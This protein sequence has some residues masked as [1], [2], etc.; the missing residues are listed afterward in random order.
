M[1]DYSQLYN[2]FLGIFNYENLLANIYSKPSLSKA[3]QYEGYLINLSDYNILKT[4]IGY[5]NLLK[6]KNNKQK[7]FKDDFPNLVKKYKLTK[8]D[9]I[10]IEQKNV[11]SAEEILKLIKEGNKYKIIDKNL[12][13]IIRAKNKNKNPK[14]FNYDYEINS[15]NLKFYGLSFSH[16]NNIIDEFSYYIGN[17]NKKIINLAKSIIEYYY[18]EEQFISNENDNSNQKNKI[19]PK[20]R[21]MSIDRFKYRN[22]NY[23]DQFN[24]NL[25]NNYVGLLINQKWIK[26]WKKYTN[27]NEIKKYL[28]HNNEQCEEIAEKI[29]YYQKNNNEI[30]ELDQIEIIYFESKDEYDNYMRQNNLAIINNKFYNCFAQGMNNYINVSKIKYS[31]ENNITTIYFDDMQMDFISTKNILLG[32]LISNLIILK[33]IKEFQEGLN[34]NKLNSKFDEI[35][36]VEK[37]WIQELKNKYLYNN[38]STE[39]KK[40]NFPS[41]NILDQVSREYLSKVKEIEIKNEFNINS[42]E[43]LKIINKEINN[44]QMKYITEF[45]IINIKTYSFLKILYKDFSLY[46][47]EGEYY[48]S[49]NSLYSNIIICFKDSYKNYYYQIGK[50]DKN[51]IYNANYVLNFNYNIDSKNL[52]KNVL[53]FKD[54]EKEFFNRI[55][56]NENNNNEFLINYN[57]L[58]HFYKLNYNDDFDCLQNLFLSI[59]KFDEEFKNK[60]MNKGKIYSY[61]NCY[62]TCKKFLNEFKKIFLY[63]DYK[64]NSKQNFDNIFSDKKNYEKLFDYENYLILETYSTIKNKQLLYP[65][66]FDIINEDIFNNLNTFAKFLNNEISEFMIIQT[67]LIINE[68][69]IIIKLSPLNILVIKIE[70]NNEYIPEIIFD[71][72]KCDIKDGYF[73]ILSKNN[74]NDVINDKIISFIYNEKNEIIGNKYLVNNIINKNINNNNINEDIIKSYLKIILEFY[75]INEN[76]SN[77]KSRL[78]SLRPTINKEELYIVNKKWVDEFRYIFC[79][80]EILDTLNKNRFLISNNDIIN[81]IYNKMNNES[82]KYLNNLNENIIFTKFNN[83]NLYKLSDK[84]HIINENN[85]LLFFDTCGFI[86]EQLINLIKI[87][88]QI[89]KANCIFGDDKI[90]LRIESM[91]YIVILKNNLFYT[92]YIINLNNNE[93]LIKIEN[94]IKIKGFDYINKLFPRKF[95]K[96]N[97]N[98]IVLINEVNN[99]NNILYDDSNLKNMDER[100]KVLLILCIYQLKFNFKKNDFKYNNYLYLI[101]S[102]FLTELNHDNLFSILINIIEKN[103]ELLSDIKSNEIKEK[104]ILYKLCKYINKEMI[105]DFENGIKNINIPSLEQYFYSRKINLILSD[106]KNINVYNNFIIVD[107]NIIALFK[108]IF[109]F[110][111]INLNIINIFHTYSDNKNF[112]LLNDENRVLLGNI[113][114]NGNYFKLEYIFD[115]FKEILIIPELTKLINNYYEYFKNNLN[116]SEIY[117]NDYIS[118]IFLFNKKDIIGYCYKYNNNIIM[119]NYSKYTLNNNLSNIIQKY[120]YDSIL[121]NILIKKEN[122]FINDYYL[123]NS[124]FLKEY[125]NYYSYS[126][127]KKELNT[128]KNHPIIINNIFNELLNNNK[129]I[130]TTKLFYSLVKFLNPD[131]NIKFNNLKK[132]IKLNEKDIKPFKIKLNFYDYIYLSNEIIKIDTDFELIH[133]NILGFFF[134]I[135]NLERN[136]IS[137]NIIKEYILINYPMDINNNNQ[138]ITLIGNLND[139]NIFKTNYILMYYSGNERLKHIQ[140]LKNYLM[141]YLKRIS[142]INTNIPI[143]NDRNEVIGILIK[144]D[145]INKKYKFLELKYNEE[146]T[147]NNILKNKNDELIRELQN[148]KLNNYNF[149]NQ[150]DKLSN[151]LEKD[152]KI[153]LNNEINQLKVNLNNDN[154]NKSNVG[155]INKDNT[156]KFQLN[157]L[158][159]KEKLSEKLKDNKNEI[160]EIESRYPIILLKEEKLICVILMSLDKKVNYPIICKSTDKFTKIEE[161]LYEKFPEFN[162]NGNIFIV[163]GQKINKNKTL[164]FNNIKYGDI[165]TFYQENNLNKN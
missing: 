79:Y 12:Y 33:Q 127:V 2:Y 60:I 13:E 97:N 77:E 43:K 3:I 121:T 110:N 6:E 103:K 124:N 88:Q 9:I 100:L 70:N 151:E 11:D 87:K 38:Y 1:E 108:E 34:L 86:N 149:P 129:K 45:E 61:E 55:Y 16:R 21:G 25:N 44:I 59:N 143:I 39:I 161:L 62:V 83:I 128:M 118:P 99:L 153:N 115:Y 119:N 27:Y 85:S 144:N 116:F 57:I 112:I 134:D 35:I 31:F 7:N 4:K 164:E 122:I 58:C 78:I 47:Y 165:I 89:C 132:E 8:K 148:I 155:L 141:D 72:D 98:D 111:L 95:I 90:L 139:Q 36:M 71:F 140:F 113:M 19:P 63:E 145:D 81:I 96:T 30:K 104:E 114:N 158:N 23:K 163:N 93:N 106:K 101:N 74:F 142:L 94:I 53:Y 82:K 126:I 29:F 133:K 68:N 156:N 117:E 28:N 69:K 162:E 37:N 152:N 76:I 75:K 41:M 65:N 147:N 130:D 138:C 131:L 92:E 52:F 42:K 135:N 157:E 48:I 17:G 125:E 146:K 51:K 120:I 64:N 32:K 40:I 159:Q 107:K 109:N 154:K 137:F 80:D 123:V 91:I 67:P 24:I 66:N 10:K 150:I 46:S 26:Q 102:K 14:N 160:K 50:I 18:I 56:F 22:S 54:K 15:K 49:N 5:D 136:L 73:K 84:K 20:K 105:F